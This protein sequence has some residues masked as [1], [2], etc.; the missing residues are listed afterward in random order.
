M[1]PRKYMS[2]PLIFGHPRYFVPVCIKHK[3]GFYGGP[4]GY[5]EMTREVALEK[6]PIILIVDKS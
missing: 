2:M 5:Q 6:S 3:H 1:K 4:A